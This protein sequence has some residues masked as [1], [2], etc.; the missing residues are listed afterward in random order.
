MFFLFWTSCFSSSKHGIWFLC[1]YPT[2]S[3][4][5]FDK[6]APLTLTSL[7]FLEHLFPIQDFCFYCSLCLEHWPSPI[8]TCFILSISLHLCSDFTSS[9]RPPMIIFPKRVFL[10]FIFSLAWNYTTH[11]FVQ[12]FIVYLPPLKCK[13]QEDRAL[14]FLYMT[15]FGA[16]I[17]MPGHGR[18]HNKYL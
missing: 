7:L 2:L 11:S 9:K 1:I 16:P 6:S 18:H 3:S 12:L 15:L 5:S 10:F 13:F 14:I 4:I 17:T 8:F